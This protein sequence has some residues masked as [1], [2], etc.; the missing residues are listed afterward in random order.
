[1]NR[2][3]KRAG[4]IGL[5]VFVVFVVI[6][7]V[8][9]GRFSGP[10]HKNNADR[11]RASV[12]DLPQAVP[13]GAQDPSGVKPMPIPIVIP[14]GAGHIVESYTAAG[15]SAGTVIHIQD[16]HTNYEAQKNLSKILES[17]I[18]ENQ[19]KL[20]MVEG[21]WGN[22]NLSYLRSY[23]GSERRQSVAEDYLKEGKISGEEYLDIVSD[24]DIKI[25]GAEDE[26][27]YRANLDTFFAIDA[28]RQQAASE[29]NALK[30]VIEKL[31]QS[32]YT[33][34]LS[35]LER[36]KSDYDNEKISLAE[37]YKYLHAAA[38][39]EKRDLSLYPNF[40][41]F[42]SVVESESTIKFT[43]AE[44]E[45]TE[46]IE[47][48]SKILSKQELAELVTKSLEFKLNKLTPVQYHDYLMDV[49]RQSGLSL[50]AFTNL[51]KYIVYIKAHDSINT[52][53]V[54]EEANAVLRAVETARI[55]EPRQQRLYS[56]ARSA[57]VLDNF[58]HLKLVP[59]DFSYYKNNR[60]DF[61]TAG[62][63]EFLQQQAQ[64]SK[65][66]VDTIKAAYVLDKNLSTLVKFY[67]L[68]NDRDDAF[69]RHT[70]RLMKD[71]EAP[72]AVLIAGGF[73]T[74]NIK[75]KFKEHS[76]SYI[77]VAPYTSQQTDMEQYRYI[78]RYKSGKEE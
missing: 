17:L 2:Q 49:A 43:L 34:Q 7:W 71:E 12:T 69:M 46:L 45:R 21:G 40:L 30:N 31:K 47:R 27:L 61:I 4:I 42:M 52:A 15:A 75:Q 16:I 56:I 51:E 73:H 20:I 74:P 76:L 41:R 5:A 29:L 57:Q 6:A 59:D 24:Y 25:E 32:I 35:E 3:Y 26:S 68:A 14:E 78:L 64:R 10:G 11:P 48:L 39:K 62:W 37:Y 63:I 38:A 28:F 54:F 60:N 58:L 9:A 65:I 8:I 50:Q 22:V 70:L 23:A 77:V 36:V 53:A 13:T 67:D 33:P 1:M 19:L 72:V 18:N 44:K 55:H 66:D